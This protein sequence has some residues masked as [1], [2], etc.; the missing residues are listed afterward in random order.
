M[1]CRQTISA[2]SQIN[3]GIAT[4]QIVRPNIFKELEVVAALQ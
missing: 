2:G 3:E 1:L 4:F